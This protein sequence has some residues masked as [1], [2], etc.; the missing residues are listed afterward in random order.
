M[1]P[2]PRHLLATV[3]ILVAALG[4]SLAP[5]AARAATV[6]LA[7]SGQMAYSYEF[8]ANSTGY[9]TL[10]GSTYQLDV[11]GTYTFSNTLGAPA[12]TLGTSPQVGSYSFQDSYVFTIAQGASG[13]VLTASLQLQFP[14]APTPTL[15]LS[16]LQFRL[17]QVVS[18]S[19]PPVAVG[20]P[21]GSTVVTSWMGLASPGTATISATFGNIGA[22]TYILDVAGLPSGS[23]GGMYGG[24][25]QLTATPLPAAAWLLMSGAGLFGFATRRPRALNA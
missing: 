16:N 10:T 11:P 20:V 23:S 9:S 3:L 14:G 13:D 19:T 21:A 18:S 5:A 22:G 17:Y 6:P 7:G 15:D 4:A 25:V 2:V 1:N 12:G 8:L 24:A